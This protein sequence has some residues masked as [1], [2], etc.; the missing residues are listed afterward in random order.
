MPRLVYRI[1]SACGALGYGYPKESVAE[2]GL[3]TG[4]PGPSIS[5]HALAKYSAF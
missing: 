5:A 2:A 1:V 4:S 3:A